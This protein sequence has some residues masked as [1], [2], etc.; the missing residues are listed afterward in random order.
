MSKTSSNGHGRMRED[1]SSVSVNEQRRSFLMS[2]GRAGKAVAAAY[3]LRSAATIAAPAALLRSDRALARPQE[4]LMQPSEIRSENGILKTTISAGPARVQL[5][6]VAFP[7]FVYNGSYLPPLLRARL[8]DTMRITLRNDLS[9]DPTNLHYHGMTVSP[10]GNSDNV[11]LHVHPGRSSTTRCAFRTPAGRG[12]AS[13]G[14]IRMLME[15]LPS[16]SSAACR[17]LSSLTGQTSSFPFCGACP[18]GSCSSNTRSLMTG[19]RSSRSTDRST[20]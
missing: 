14:T 2:M 19:P 1:R 15:L 20:R 10:R 18:N 3:V 7:G 5:G 16:K 4:L 12:P 9:D 11:F 8:G 17:A 13:S 6:E